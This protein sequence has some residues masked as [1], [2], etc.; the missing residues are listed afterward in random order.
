MFIKKLNILLLCFI[1]GN[2][3]GLSNLE[4]NHAIKEYLT[5]NGIL[6]NFTINKKLKLPNCKKNIEVKKRFESFKTLEI[7]CPQEN[8]WTY[9]IRIKIQNIKKKT[10]EKS[11]C[12]L[13]IIFLINLLEVNS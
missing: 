4:I 7:I 3:F 13:F 1:V 9:N 12:I 5:Q 2:A 6:Q 8:P 10:T 11:F